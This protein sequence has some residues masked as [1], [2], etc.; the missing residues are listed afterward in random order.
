MRRDMFECGDSWY[1]TPSRLSFVP[2]MYLPRP[3]AT[4]GSCSVCADNVQT[5]HLELSSTSFPT[6][7]REAAAGESVPSQRLDVC[8]DAQRRAE[9]RHLDIP[10]RAS[11]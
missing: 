6:C 2:P 3:H 4:T 9:Q 10:A 1:R 5:R 11:S 8:A 7:A